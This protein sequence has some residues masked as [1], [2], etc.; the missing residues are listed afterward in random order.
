MRRTNS[1][2]SRALF[3]PEEPHIDLETTDGRRPETSGADRLMVGLAAIALLGGALVG[4]SRFL[5]PPEQEASKASGSPQATAVATPTP[6]ATPS[7]ALAEQLRTVRIGEEPLPPNEPPISENWGGWARS[8]HRI[9][10]YQ[11]PSSGDPG[12]A[13]VAAGAPMQIDE[14]TPGLF[15][16]DEGWMQIHLPA[17]G[18]I[19][20]RS[21]RNA[22]LVRFGDERT[23]AYDA[24]ESIIPGADGRYV[25]AGIHAA[26]G[27]H[28]LA[29][30]EDGSTWEPVGGQGLL[31]D[32]SFL[33][34]AYGPRDWVAVVARQTAD[35]S[36]LWA[37][38]STDGRNWRLLGS[39]RT[40]PFATIG[41]FQLVGSPL[42]YVLTFP[43]Y[44]YPGV[45]PTRAWY[46]ADAEVWSER[47]TLAPTG[48]VAASGVGFYAYQPP[49]YYP[50][51][52]PPQNPTVSGFSADG[53][54]WTSVSTPEMTHLVGVA[55]AADRLVAL[56]AVAA[57]VQPWVGTVADGTLTWRQDDASTGAFTNAVVT[58]L[59]GTLTPIAMGYDRASDAPLW[60]SNDAAGWH[61]HRLPS[62]FGGP[63]VTGAANA[64]TV[65]LIGQRSSILGSTPVM[66]SGQEDSTL[67]P[68]SEP[69]IPAVPDLSAADCSRYSRDLLELMTQRSQIQVHCFGNAPVTFTVHVPT[70]DECMGDPGDEPWTPAWLMLSKPDRYLHMA[71]VSSDDYGWFDGILAPGVRAGD[72]EHRWVRVTGHFDD[73]AARTCQM[74]SSPGGDFGFASRQQVIDGCREVFVVTSVTVLSERDSPEY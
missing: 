59:A 33:R 68:E 21:G 18:W 14:G 41:Y 64:G 12:I 13:V 3:D 61:P 70:C 31:D 39:L 35:R 22:N 5:P 30:S 73:P 17:E 62:S 2:A 38:Q 46:S 74:H 66:W 28:F 4:I 48:N 65:V 55:G 15:D 63:A 6:R 67:H 42:G 53:W 69:L 71:P 11:Y 10:V 44:G 47:D 52:G 1:R 37:W 54:D 56:N 8:T 19:R 23:P 43:S 50:L 36:S 29:M 9:T 40:L 20:A 51:D 57:G 45:E 49:N 27:S 34:I 26:D 16:P 72:W 58:S 32:A 60:W 25:L 24:V 7:V